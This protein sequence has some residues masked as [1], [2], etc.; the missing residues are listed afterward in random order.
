ME[1]VES[2]LPGGSD[3]DTGV[4]ETSP[5]VRFAHFAFDPVQDLL[6]EG[7]LSEVYR[8]RDEKLGR[9]VA[10]KILRPHV[11]L[12]PEADRRFEREARHTSNLAHPNI[13]TIFEYG[14]DSGRCFIAMEFLSGRTLDKIVKD[15]QLGLDEALRI[16]VQLTSALA[17]VH[18]VGLIH[19]DLKPANVMVQDDGAIKLLDFGIA[20]ANGEPTITQHGMLVGTVLYMSPEQVRGDEL[21]ARADMFSLGAMLY[22]ALT[23]QLPFP[24]KSF[25]EV[26]MSILDGAPRPLGQ[27]RSGLPP[28]LDEFVMRCLD[29]DPSR[30]YADATQAHGVLESIVDGLAARR[31][32]HVSSPLSGNLAFAPF[33]T[34][35]DDAI[36]GLAASIRKDISAALQRSGLAITLLEGQA[37]PDEAGADYLLRGRVEVKGEEGALDLE[38]S[39]TSP[40]TEPWSANIRQSDDDEWVLQDSLVRSAVRNLRKQLQDFAMRPTA[41]ASPRDPAKAIASARRGHAVLHKGMTKHLLASISLFRQ[42]IEQDPHCALGYAGLGEALARKFLYWDGDGSFLE[43]G[44]AQA[45]RAVAVDPAC[46]EAHTSI[47]FAFHLSGALA[48]AQREYRLAIQ[49]NNDEWFA[50]R[51]LGA[52]L[53]REGNFKGA[54]P[55]LKRAI[56]IR[57]S[58]ISTYDHLYIVLQRLDRYQ[59]AIETADRGIELARV[60]LQATPDDQ[61][62]RVHLATLLA[63]MGLRD[64]VLSEVERAKELGRKDGFTNFHLGIVHAVLGDPEQAVAALTMAQSRGYFVRSEARNTEFDILRG[65][66]EF[67][68][69]LS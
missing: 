6:G 33:D 47:G 14:E 63:R 25:P 61:D 18:R 54:S 36:R 21:D 8:A 38:L 2:G 35:A 52:I 12:D 16:A 20:R 15:A 69:L 5:L 4:S 34:G 48:D 64:E 65:M 9:T 51:L 68:A 1:P 56:A 67:Q 44:R 17:L 32:I 13:A 42:A 28:E 26:C 29:P 62:S 24:G 41:E 43:E 22:H 55:L 53:S 23:G 59:E 19:R 27:V 11:D 60:R 40:G 3:D 10:L 7:P 46:A 57:P 30:R 31:G 37:A 49:L 39:S 66:P 58:Y 45:R 50:H